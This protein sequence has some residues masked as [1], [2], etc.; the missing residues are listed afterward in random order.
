MCHGY[1]GPGVSEPQIPASHYPS[2]PSGEELLRKGL[3][4]G[5]FTGFSERER[6]R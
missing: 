1:S 6:E 3:C 5:G 4:P 2:L